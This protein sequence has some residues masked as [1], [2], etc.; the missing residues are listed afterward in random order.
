M[1]DQQRARARRIGLV[2]IGRRDLV[3]GDDRVAVQVRVVDEKEPVLGV[4][5]VEGHGEEAAL[6]AEVDLAPEVE[7]RLG[8]H[9]AAVQDD[10]PA[11]AE[12]HEQAGVRRV[13][14]GRRRAELLLEQVEP[15]ARQNARGR[16]RSG[17]RGGSLGEGLRG[18]ERKDGRQERRGAGAEKGARHSGLSKSYR[19]HQAP[20]MGFHPPR[21]GPNR[22]CASGLPPDGALRRR[23]T[24]EAGSYTA[25]PS[26]PSP[27]QS[28]A[29]ASEPRPRGPN[30]NW[31]SMLPVNELASMKNDSVGS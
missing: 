30:W 10:D 2:G 15:H 21:R 24:A 29:T 16:E 23:K 3:A 6:V 13:G 25:T 17:R 20:A 14:D 4:A 11:L 9:R 28:P 8:Q 26:R 19:R 18:G 22:N 31:R 27:S 1:D 12:D 5:G 7:E